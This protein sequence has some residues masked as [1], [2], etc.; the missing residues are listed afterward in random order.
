MS[1]WLYP[2]K[3]EIQKEGLVKLEEGRNKVDA[4]QYAVSMHILV[5]KGAVFY[6]GCPW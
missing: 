6:V 5:F 2:V 4:H 3:I 1:M